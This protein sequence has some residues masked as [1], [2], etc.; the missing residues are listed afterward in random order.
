MPVQALIVARIL[1]PGSIPFRDLLRDVLEVVKALV[2][3]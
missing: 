2:G 1:A 3:K